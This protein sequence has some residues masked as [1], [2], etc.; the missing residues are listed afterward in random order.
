MVSGEYVW[1][2]QKAYAPFSL[3]THYCNVCLKMVSLTCGG[4]S[5]ACMMSWGTTS[6]YVR[7]SLPNF[8]LSVECH[9][10]VAAPLRPA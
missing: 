7:A 3:L 5:E 10:P 8:L 1:M 9:S 6:V 4:P 2:Q